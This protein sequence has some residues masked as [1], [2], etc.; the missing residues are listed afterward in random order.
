MGSIKPYYELNCQIMLMTYVA[1][2]MGSIKPYYELNCQI[3]TKTRYI[4]SIIAIHFTKG[5]VYSSNKME[6]YS[7]KM[8]GCMLSQHAF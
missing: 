7:K 4:H 6:L 3:I 8:S 5:S 2:I 1:K